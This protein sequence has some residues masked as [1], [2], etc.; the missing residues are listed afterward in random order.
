MMSD[1]GVQRIKRKKS[2]HE[3]NEAQEEKTKN[4]S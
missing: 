2:H 4:H 3:E 1:L